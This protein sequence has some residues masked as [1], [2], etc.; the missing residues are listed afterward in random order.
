MIP[1]GAHQTE[2]LKL[3][4]VLLTETVFEMCVQVGDKGVALTTADSVGH[5]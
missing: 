4:N 2:L 1:T 3:I 5:L